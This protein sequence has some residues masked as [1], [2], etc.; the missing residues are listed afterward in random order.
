MSKKNV[1]RCPKCGVGAH[2]HPKGMKR[3]K[4]C[5][6]EYGSECEGLLCECDQCENDHDPDSDPDAEDHGLNAGNPCANAN[7]YHCGWGGR[8]P[9]AKAKKVKKVRSEAEQALI[10]VLDGNGAWY[11]IQ[12]RTGLPESRC[13]EIAA[14]F[15]RLVAKG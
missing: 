9:P 12:E 6:E 3:P 7:C 10:E 4:S 5:V 2:E 15:E 11:E 1:W 14:L 13:R 8:I